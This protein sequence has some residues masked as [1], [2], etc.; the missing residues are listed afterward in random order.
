MYAQVYEPCDQQDFLDAA[1]VYIGAGIDHASGLKFAINIDVAMSEVFLSNVTG[2][3]LNEPLF[4]DV[5]V[6]PTGTRIAVVPPASG[7]DVFSSDCPVE[8]GPQ[9]AA[10]LATFADDGQSG[11]VRYS[12]RSAARGSPAAPAHPLPG[13][14]DLSGRP[15][16]A[17]SVSGSMVLAWT[18]ERVRIL[19]VEVPGNLLLRHAFTWPTNDRTWEAISRMS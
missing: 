12:I 7:R 13:F 10:V 9:A 6:L 16:E 1:A 19:E 17:L 2:R 14:E 11:G 3:G 15:P 4:D 5:A 8:A 18:G